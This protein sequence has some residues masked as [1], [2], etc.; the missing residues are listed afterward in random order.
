MII[1][2]VASDCDV[3]PSIIQVGCPACCYLVCALD[4]ANGGAADLDHLSEPCYDNFYSKV[5][6]AENRE[7]T[8]R[9]DS[10][11]LN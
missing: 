11:N 1:K 8:Q 6:F 7:P 4:Q 10:S 3:R 2:T 9:S 5:L